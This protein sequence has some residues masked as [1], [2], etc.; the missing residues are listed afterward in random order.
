MPRSSWLSVRIHGWPIILVW[1]P[2]W[3]AISLITKNRKGRLALPN[4]LNKK[5][6]K[7][8]L[9]EMPRGLLAH[10]EVNAWTIRIHRW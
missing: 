7:K 8:M 1:L 5:Q 10:I 9:R 2:D 6:F 4:N 3:L